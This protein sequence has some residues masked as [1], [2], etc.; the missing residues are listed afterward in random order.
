MYVAPISH[1]LLV[2]HIGSAPDKNMYF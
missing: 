1:A 2:G